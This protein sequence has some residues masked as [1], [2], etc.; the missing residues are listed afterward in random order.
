MRKCLSMGGDDWNRQPS[1]TAT[2]ALSAGR[3]SEGCN[4]ALLAQFGCKGSAFLAQS[5]NSVDAIVPNHPK[6]MQQRYMK[7]GRSLTPLSSERNPF[8][9]EFSDSAAAF[10]AWLTK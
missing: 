8:N 10:V 1:L 4:G 2:G 5:T 6:I 3:R 7:N 9:L